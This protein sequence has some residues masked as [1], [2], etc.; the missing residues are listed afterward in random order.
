MHV[1]SYYLKIKFI[2]VR[3]ILMNGNGMRCERYASAFTNKNIDRNGDVFCSC[4]VVIVFAENL[5]SQR[6]KL[7]VHKCAGL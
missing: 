7:T 2:L 6:K 1:F 3:S 4:Y 5:W